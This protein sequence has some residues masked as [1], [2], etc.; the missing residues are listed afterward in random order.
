MAVSA[1]RVRQRSIAVAAG[2]WITYA[3]LACVPLAEDPQQGKEST[4]EAAQHYLGAEG[5]L[6]TVVNGVWTWAGPV[7]EGYWSAA[8]P[9]DHGA[10]TAVAAHEAHLVRKERGYEPASGSMAPSAPPGEQDG[11]THFPGRGNETLQPTSPAS[12]SELDERGIGEDSEEDGA[13]DGSNRPASVEDDIA[14]DPVYQE[15]HDG[16]DVERS[17]ASQLDHSSSGHTYRIKT[18]DRRRSRRRSRRRVKTTTRKTTTSTTST[19]TTTTTT[20]TVSFTVKAG[21]RRVSGEGWS[22]T[23]ALTFAVLTY[24]TGQGRPPDG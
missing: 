2:L 15:E 21:S 23:L 8:K 22:T 5:P 11:Q 6:P 12:A 20:T 24:L 1:C 9:V 10:H 14:E 19:T 17:V 3:P 4:R 18:D 13:G 7:H 16:S